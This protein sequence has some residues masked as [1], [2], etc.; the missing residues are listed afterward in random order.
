MMEYWAGLIG[1]AI[2]AAIMAFIAGGCIG[3]LWR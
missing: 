3:E 2:A 1:Y